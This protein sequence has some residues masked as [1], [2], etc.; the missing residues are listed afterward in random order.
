MDLPPDKDI[1][2]VCQSR[3]D[4]TRG[5]LSVG[6]ACAPGRH[7][8]SHSGLRSQSP[9]E[10]VVGQNRPA[11]TPVG[12]AEMSH[13]AIVLPAAKQWFIFPRFRWFYGLYLLF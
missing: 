9:A 2:F 13:P 10:G 3:A 4:E 7:R 5:L 11:A 6:G 12:C 8:C 1:R